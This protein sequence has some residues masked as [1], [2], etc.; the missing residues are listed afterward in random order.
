MICRFPQTVEF[1]PTG[2]TEGKEPVL[3][4][5]EEYETVRLIDKEGLSQEQCSQS[6]GKL[7]TIRLLTGKRLRKGA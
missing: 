2:G 1:M 6:M 7:L 4:T 3:L 5:V